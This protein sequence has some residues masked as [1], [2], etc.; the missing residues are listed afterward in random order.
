M[1]IGILG[2]GLMGGKLGTLFARAGQESATWAS[3]RWTPV[4]SGW[5]ATPS[6]LHCSSPISP[7]GG[8]GGRN[9]RTG[10]SGSGGRLGKTA[11]WMEKVSDEQYRAGSS[12]E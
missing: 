11:D 8:N 3:I 2:S 1:R 6:R 9:W 7:T 12:A 10:S 5:P 4:P